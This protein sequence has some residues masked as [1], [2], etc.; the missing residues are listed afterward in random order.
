MRL[1]CVR[2]CCIVFCDVF[3]PL[4]DSRFATHFSNQV[5]C[6]PLSSTWIA[7]PLRVS[8][9]GGLVENGYGQIES[10]AGKTWEFIE[11][12]CEMWHNCTMCCVCVVCIVCLLCTLSMFVLC[13]VP[14]N[15]V[16]ETQAAQVVAPPAEKLVLLATALERLHSF[17]RRLVRVR[18]CDP[19][20]IHNTYYTCVHTFIDT[21]TERGNNSHRS[22]PFHRSQHPKRRKK[23]L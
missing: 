5:I 21:H 10:V 18:R 13:V 2:V 9:R 16:S 20:K 12:R 7:H 4:T 11:E 1:W 22:L 15:A 14:N 3:C 19:L 6:G 17:C 23:L 8:I